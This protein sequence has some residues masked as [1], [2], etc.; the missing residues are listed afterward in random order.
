MIQPST[1]YSAGLAILY[2][3]KILL[4][5]TTGKRS[6]NSFGIPKGAIEPGESNIDA[7]IR[8]TYEEIG[9]K[10]P[11]EMIDTT[12]HTFCLTSGKRTTKVVYYYIVK[13][14]DLAQLGLEELEVPKEQLQVEEIDSAGFFGYEEAINKVMQSQREVIHSLLFFKYFMDYGTCWGSQL[15]K[16]L[17]R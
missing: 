10:I 16:S 14:D 9:I 7:A 15:I 6:T 12:E 17:N 4:G 5:H 13:V 3:E 1:K 2:K 8:E 11:I